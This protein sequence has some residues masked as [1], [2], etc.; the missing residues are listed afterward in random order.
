M[1]GE[2]LVAL[3]AINKTLQGL[4]FVFSVGFCVLVFTR[5]G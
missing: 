1:E 2:I 4:V 3:L 5:K